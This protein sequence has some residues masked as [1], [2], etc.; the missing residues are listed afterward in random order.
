MAMEVKAKSAEIIFVSL[1]PINVLFNS[2]RHFKE[3]KNVYEEPGVLFAEVFHFLLKG[4]KIHQLTLDFYLLTRCKILKHTLDF[5]EV[6]H[7][8][9]ASL[10]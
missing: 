9:L 1:A 4:W 2:V 6:N 10:F 7:L 3:F 8:K 5:A